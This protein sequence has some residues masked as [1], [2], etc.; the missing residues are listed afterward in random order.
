[1][2][3]VAAPIYSM[4]RRALLAL[5]TII[6]L[7]VVIVLPMLVPEPMVDT[8]AEL[9]SDKTYKILPSR[10]AELSEF[11]R[12]SQDLLAQTLT[13]KK[14]L[15]EQ[16]VAQWGALAFDASIEF[17]TRGDELYNQGR[18]EQA[19]EAYES[20]LASM[21]G[22]LARGQEILA[23]AKI[24]SI[25]AI[26]RA[27]GKD[28]ILRAK[29]A[30]ALANAIAP[31]DPDVG[32]IMTRVASLETVI[33]VLASANEKTKA[34][35]FAQA[36]DI[37][38]QALTLDPRHLRTATLLQET[39]EKLLQQQF[40]KRMSQAVKAIDQKDFEDAENYLEQAS[41]LAVDTLAVS[42]LRDLLQAQKAQWRIDTRLDT[43]IEYEQKED[44]A[45][46]VANYD[47]ILSTDPNLSDI[48]IMRLKAAARASL[49]R[50][51]KA[52]IQDPLSLAS[53]EKFDSAKNTLSDINKISNPGVILLE[54]R[55]QLAKII[56]QIKVPVP[57][58]F[59]SDRQTEVTLFRVSRLGRFQSTTVSLRPGRYTL[60]GERPGFRDVRIDFTVLPGTEIQ[61]ILVECLEKI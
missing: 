30:S 57:V 51:I 17:I 25:D 45:T 61:P 4:K 27:S 12:Q 24:S 36:I 7:A 33:G 19:L 40:Q 60:A 52:I 44:W 32:I 31:E 46:A 21:R 11:R 13:A 20:A 41:N 39:R 53:E 50:S 42:Q 38:E 18:F 59:Q 29:Q 9:V 37:L 8:S 47:D 26:E 5:L 15:L 58:T 43:A 34:D 10:A 54:Q 16:N 56:A 1:M 28:D 6:A 3:S 48:A 49:D 55:Q 35:E 22:L 2:D 14:Q 23:N